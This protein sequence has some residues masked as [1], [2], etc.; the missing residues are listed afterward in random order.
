V[1]GGGCSCRRILLENCTTRKNLNNAV[2]QCV[3]VCV[4]VCEEQSECLRVLDPVE[5]GSAVLQ[6]PDL[7][8][9]GSSTE[10]GPPSEPGT[11]PLSPDPPLSL[12]S[13]DNFLQQPCTSFLVLLKYSFMFILHPCLKSRHPACCLPHSSL[14]DIFI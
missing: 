12:T 1:G 5:K 6:D 3:C 7:L 14:N 13:Q 4:C 9:T 8:L 11:P 2:S 10:P